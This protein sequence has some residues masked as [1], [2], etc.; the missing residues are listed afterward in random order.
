MEAGVAQMKASCANG[1]CLVSHPQYYRRFGFVNP[2]GLWV[3][4]VPN[5][6]FFARSFVGI[7]PQGLVTF[8][9]AFQATDPKSSLEDPS[10]T[11]S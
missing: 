1:C 7:Y 2:A 5:E 9:Q 11:S 10:S 4:G 3:E 8:H 6:V